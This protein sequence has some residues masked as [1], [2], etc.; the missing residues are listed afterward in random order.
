MLLA[1]FTYRWTTSNLQIGLSISSQSLIETLLQ[2]LPS[3]IQVNYSLLC[4]RTLE[5][6]FQEM[7]GDLIT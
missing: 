6:R 2:D 3:K 5:L 4:A 1:A 7:A